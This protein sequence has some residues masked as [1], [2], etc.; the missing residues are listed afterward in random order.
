LF[1]YKVDFDFFKGKDFEE[2][3]NPTILESKNLTIDNC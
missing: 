1:L 3:F 2:S